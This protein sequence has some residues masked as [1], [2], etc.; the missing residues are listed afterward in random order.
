MLVGLGLPC[1]VPHGT[2]LTVKCLLS[3]SV[4]LDLPGPGTSRHHLHGQVSIVCASATR[5]TW[6]R[7]L[8]AQSSRSCV[9]CLCQC[10]SVYLAMVSHGT[11]FT[12]KCLLF[13]LVRL[14]LPGPGTS[15]HHLHG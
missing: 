11:T 5:C 14:G 7:Y 6:S 15:R 9:Y 13:M 1:Q 4:G 2:T 10:D 12:V 3:M 8:T